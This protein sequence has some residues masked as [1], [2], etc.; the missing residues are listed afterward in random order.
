MNIFGASICIGRKILDFKQMLTGWFEKNKKIKKTAH[1][2]FKRP[3][4]F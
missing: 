2:Y 3:Y 4:F 1:A